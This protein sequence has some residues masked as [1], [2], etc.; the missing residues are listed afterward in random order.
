MWE[1]TVFGG[2]ST[3]SSRTKLPYPL[4]PL[5]SFL[6]GELGE[7]W[8]WMLRRFCHAACLDGNLRLCPSKPPV[9]LATS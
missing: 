8:V 3:E 5:G 6:L 4:L 1:W 9:N 2:S 7:A